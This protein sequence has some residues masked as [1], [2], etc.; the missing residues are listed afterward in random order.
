MGSTGA[1]G[2]ANARVRVCGVCS[3]LEYSC[4]PRIAV[5]N[6]ARRRAS[7]ESREGSAGRENRGR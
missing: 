4:A 2:A 1:V 3:T 5:A 7:N 6:Y